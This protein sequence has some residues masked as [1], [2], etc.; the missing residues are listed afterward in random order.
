[1]EIG[2]LLVC[3]PEGY[4]RDNQHLT[5]KLGFRIL[6]LESRNIDCK[7]IFL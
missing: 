7:D 3:V 5:F 1:M 2:M 6:E 4:Y